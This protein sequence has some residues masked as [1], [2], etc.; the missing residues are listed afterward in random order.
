MNGVVYCCCFSEPE[1]TLYPSGNKTNL[2]K[3]TLLMRKKYKFYRSIQND[4]YDSA[5]GVYELFEINNTVQGFWTCTTVSILIIFFF[6][7]TVIL[8]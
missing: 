5:P 2:F 3:A 8:K 4:V 6:F 1:Q 7:G